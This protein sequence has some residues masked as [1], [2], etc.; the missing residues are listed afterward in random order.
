MCQDNLFKPCNLAIFFVMQLHVLLPVLMEVPAYLLTDVAVDQDGL[1]AVALQVL[2][3][4]CVNN[5]PPK[6]FGL[7]NN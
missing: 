5:P 2:M 6:Y 3:Y 1:V 4:S 7:L